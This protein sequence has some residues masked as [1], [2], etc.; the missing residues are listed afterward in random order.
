[1]SK[2]MAEWIQ[3]ERDSHIARSLAW[4]D[5]LNGPIQKKRVAQALKELEEEAKTEPDVGRNI[6]QKGDTEKG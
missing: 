3:E 4:L 6:D 2:C 1:M 5:K